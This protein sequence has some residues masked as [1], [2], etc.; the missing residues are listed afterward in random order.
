MRRLLLCLSLMVLVGGLAAPTSAY[1]QQAVSIYVGGF[2][3]RGEDARVD[4]DV[5][6]N[7]L[8]F[9]YFDIDKFKGGT[10]GGE[11]LAALNDRL[12]VGLGLG[13][14]SEEVPSSY[15]FLVNEDGSEI[16]QDLRLRIVPFTASFRVIPFGRRAAVQPYVGA[17]VGVLS[18]RYSETGD[19]VDFD[20][21]VFHDRFA[22]TGTT[23]G[24]LILGGVRFPIGR[25]NLGFE[26][27]HQ[28]GEGTIE[29]PADFAGATKVDLG[30]FNYLATF[31][32]R[33]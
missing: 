4:G 20:G 10:I 15:A 17:G 22:A 19:F 31:N 7:N 33:F 24:P 28:S 11:W 16:R 3:P 8:D 29:H 30:G 32:I 12:E 1:A 21:F 18:W 26:I 13:Y 14:Y 23:V 27:R 25:F 9:F 5:L 2:V 6:F